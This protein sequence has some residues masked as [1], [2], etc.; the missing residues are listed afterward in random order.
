M[1]DRDDDLIV[2]IK[3]TAILFGELDRYMIAV[4]QTLALRHLVLRV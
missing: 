3:S 4:L 2:G 1:V